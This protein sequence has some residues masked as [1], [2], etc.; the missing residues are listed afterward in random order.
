MNRGLQSRHLVCHSSA[1]SVALLFNGG[2][3]GALT[4]ILTAFFVVAAGLTMG[5]IVGRTWAV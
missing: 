4:Q 3:D 1:I 5:K 2:T